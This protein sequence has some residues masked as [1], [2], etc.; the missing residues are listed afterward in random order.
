MLFDV[1]E[2]LTLLNL[3]PKEGSFVTL[4]LLRELREALSF[5]DEEVTQF[6][7]KVASDRI[8]WDKDANVDKEIL[9]G[10]TMTSV[11]VGVLTELNETKKLTDAHL[12]LYEK[13]VLPG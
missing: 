12:G 9:I 3:L 5:T 8:T 6:K 10:D 1:S 7:V 2:R 13:F 4:K 11:I